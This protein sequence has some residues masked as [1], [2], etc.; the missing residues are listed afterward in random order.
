MHDHKVTTAE[1]DAL[2]EEL[3]VPLFKLSASE[4][5]EEIVE[6][7]REVSRDV[8]R[9]RWGRRRRSSAKMVVEAVLSRVRGNKS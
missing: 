2:A 6:A 9:K 4:G 1:A 3:N 8:I 5:G 7:F